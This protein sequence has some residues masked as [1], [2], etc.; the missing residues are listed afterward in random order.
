[1][2]GA[3]SRRKGHNLER[4]V[5]RQFREIGYDRA[6]TSREAD[7]LADPRGGDVAGVYPFFPQC[8][9][10]ESLG[11]HHRI[12][13]DMEPMSDEI[14]ILFHKR[15][16]QGTTVTLWAEDFLELVEMLKTEGVLK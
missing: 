15:N 2:S 6:K 8:K 14:P 11:S 16:R 9:A 10:V 5:A 4:E 7:P 13:S 12:L 1:M 3:R